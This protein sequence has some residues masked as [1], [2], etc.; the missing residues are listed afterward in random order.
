MTY[1]GFFKGMKY[2]KCEEDFDDYKK[3]KNH[4][5][6]DKI[7][8]YLKSLSVSAVAPMSTEDILDGEEI[9]Q[10]GIYEDG[11]FTFTTD[12]LHYYQKYDIGIPEE[13]EKYISSKLIDENKDWSNASLREVPYWRDGMSIE[14]YEKERDYYYRNIKNFWNGTYT[15]LWKQK[16]STSENSISDT[17]EYHKNARI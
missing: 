1:F 13:Y 5:S 17:C 3:I 12:F 9:E 2:G 8:R 16:M 6:K 10:A 7:L 15:P 4:I 11:D 14:E